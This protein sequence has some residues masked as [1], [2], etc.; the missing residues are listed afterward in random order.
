ELV[1]EQEVDPARGLTAAQVKERREKYGK[2]E[3]VERGLKSPWVIFFEQL[4]STLIMLLIGAALVSALLSDWEDAIAILV[5]VLLNALLGLQQE[6]KAEQARA[7]LKRLA[8]PHVRVRRAGHVFEIN[9]PDLT[10][11]DIVMLEA[12]RAIPADGRLLEAA[13]L[14]VQEA[15]LTGESE[16]VERDADLVLAGETALG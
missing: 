14:R 3:L 9:A 5:I 16:T 2:N 13:S 4:S 12:G 15:A 6:Y 1:A 7:A 8:V 11:G 10:V